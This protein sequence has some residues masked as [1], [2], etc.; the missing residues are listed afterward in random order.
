VQWGSLGAGEGSGWGLEVCHSHRCRKTTEC[1]IVILMVSAGD[2][3]LSAAAA[4]VSQQGV[5]VV[6]ADSTFSPLSACDSSTA[7]DC[8]NSPL[9]PDQLLGLLLLNV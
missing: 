2:N 1:V 7:S 9:P 4:A 6:A 5:G 8:S 3:L